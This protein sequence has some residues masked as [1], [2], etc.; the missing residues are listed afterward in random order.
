VLALLLASAATVTSAWAQF[1]DSIARIQATRTAAPA[2]GQAIASSPTNASG[3]LVRGI[4]AAG[5]STLLAAS[6][7]VLHGSLEGFDDGKA[8]AIGQSLAA[9][10]SLH[11]G[12]TITLVTSAAAT[13]PFAG[14]PRVRTYRVTTVFAS[15]AELDAT[16]IFM[17]AAEALAYGDN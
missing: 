4:H 3:V 14:A 7:G 5:L 12:D 13:T 9:Q 17:A 15:S 2:Q 10:L 8:V 11:V 16:H 1:P 6:G